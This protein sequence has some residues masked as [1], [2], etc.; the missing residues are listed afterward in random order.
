[1]SY[2]HWFVNGKQYSC[3]QCYSILIKVYQC[4][5]LNCWIAIPSRKAQSKQKFM[6]KLILPPT[7]NS[8][9]YAHRSQSRY[10]KLVL[11]SVHSCE[12]NFSG[13]RRKILNWCVIFLKCIIWLRSL[14]LV[15]HVDESCPFAHQKLSVFSVSSASAHLLSHVMLAGKVIILE[16]EVLVVMRGMCWCCPVPDSFPSETHYSPHPAMGSCSCSL[17]WWTEDRPLCRQLS[18]TPQANMVFCFTVKT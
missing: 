8:S 9:K 11:L 17:H 18:Q 1:M 7:I 14:C 3:R 4:N 2:E 13:R 15:V 12:E 5:V 10:M 16:K 6:R